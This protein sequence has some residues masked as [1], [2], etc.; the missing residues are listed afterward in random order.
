MSGTF[1]HT[2][3]NSGSKQKYA[4]RVYILIMR[5]TIKTTKYSTLAV[6]SSMKKIIRRRER[7]KDLSLR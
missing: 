3:D 4:Y 1:L 6:V 5:E 2:G 7:R